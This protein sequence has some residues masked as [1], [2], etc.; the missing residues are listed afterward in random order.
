LL[1][2]WADRFAGLGM[3]GAI[4]AAGLVAP[5]PVG[6]ATQAQPHPWAVRAVE[7]EALGSVS[8]KA[9]AV[10]AI[11]QGKVTLSNRGF[12]YT[13]SFAADGAFRFPSVE[14]GTYALTTEIT[15]YNL[16]KT[17]SV[18]VAA[19]AAVS[20]P[21]LAIETYTAANNTYS[22]TWKQD[23]AYAGLPKTE[24][25]E[26]VVKPTVVTVLGKAYTMADVSYAQEL[27][28]RYGIVLVNDEAAW[29]QE[30]AYRLFAVLSRI[31]QT[32][33][34]D[35]KFDPSL[36]TR[37]WVLTT[38]FINQ[39]IDLGKLAQGEVRVST[40]AFTYAAPVVA[41]IDGV[42][43][44]YFSKRLHHALVRYVTNGGTDQAAVAKILWDRYGLL[45]DRD[46][47]PLQYSQFTSEPATR[48]QQWF[49]HPDEL[50]RVINAFEELPEGF[51]KIAGFKWL[52]RRL[53]GTVNPLYPEAPAIA[54]GNGYME[55][56]ESAFSNFDEAYMTRLI[57]HEKAHYIYQFIVEKALKKTWA[58]LGGWV[59]APNPTNPDYD[60]ITGWQTTKT[61][62][63]V[64]AYAHDKNP[65]EDFAESIAAYVNNPDRLKA[66]SMAKY[67]FIR[68]NV[69]HSNSYVAVIRPDLTFTVLNL[70][71][72]YE[73]PG[74]INRISTRVT[75]APEEDKTLEVE[76]EIT[77]LAFAGNRA[78]S[79]GARIL[80][81]VSPEYP[82]ATYFD[83]G[84]AR[85][86]EKGTIFRGTQKLSKH[87]R[88]GY[89]QMPN[90]TIR[91]SVGRERYESSLLYGWKCYIN[92]PLQD[93]QIPQVKRGSTTLSVR[94]DTLQGRPVQWVT[95]GW[96]T[97]ENTGLTSYFATLVPPGAYSLQ[98]WGR[99][100]V[101]NGRTQVEVLINEFM[102]TGRYTVNQIFLKDYG[103]NASY[104]YF[105]TSPFN[106]GNSD[107]LVDVL[108][109]PAPSIEITTPNPDSVGPE[110]DVN[111]ITVKA[112]PTNP[113]APDGETLVTI[114][115][116]VRDNAA[117]YGVGN[118]VL[119]DPQGGE[120]YRWIYHRNFYT[121]FFDGDPKAW[122]KYTFETILPRGS[123][124][125]IWG[126]LQMTLSDKGGNSK[127]YG[128]LETVRFDPNS[129]AAAD[130]NIVGDPVGQS[131]RTGET[132]R[133]S[134]QT[135]GS[136]TVSYEWFKDGVS[137]A[138]GSGAAGTSGARTAQLTVANAQA[139]DAGAYYCVVTNDAGRVVSKA[140]DVRYDPVGSRLGNVSLR[141][142]LAARQP[143]IVGLTM[144]GGAKPVLMRAVGPGLAPFGVTNAMLDP[145]LTLF[146]E[147][148][149][150]ATND[151]WTSENGL[152]STA[153]AIG[154]FPLTAGS[155]DA[156]L[157]SSIA[158]G[159]T[160]QVQGAVGGNVLVEAYDAGSGSFP[161]LTNVSARSVAGSGGDAMIAGFTILGTEPKRVLLRAVGPTL[162]AFGVTGVLADPKLDVYAGPN[163]IA[164]NDNWPASLASTFTAV[165][166]FALP[167][168]SRD[169]AVELT[170]APGGYTVHV[171]PATGAAGEVLI[172]IYEV[173]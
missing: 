101:V 155:K 107:G 67:E 77:P 125:G 72:S 2:R 53:D 114:T 113:T 4:A 29:T 100:T 68:D 74:K 152:V 168:G 75:G 158:N 145:T 87:V 58:E 99:Q 41:E 44:L 105:R 11:E 36:P 92:N 94:S 63:F 85:V 112:V 35:Y 3:V 161:R 22:Y 51:H 49:K 171:S 126:L 150:V 156:V 73:Y 146:E 88:S 52:V 1:A 30:Y 139:A 137:L 20:V 81:P 124:P 21:D 70:F 121:D 119:R 7:A 39:D 111:R 169:A 80:S 160:L 9:P 159:R 147:A 136:A 43:G 12:V 118:L 97:V 167:A 170:L 95:I 31:P 24:I 17:V 151:N 61:T 106:S 127:S 128:F 103:L 90:V 143:L 76:I 164:G 163:R 138:A 141:A 91:D 165:G 10:K 148:R 134:V 142:T 64:S 83:M 130:L 14:A 56:M 166:A 122:E 120:Y 65:N 117:G 140:A 154:A 96:D 86:D 48:F 27:L 25:A 135:A 133:L 132:I 46:G 19:G 55:Y 33:G 69:M 32:M 6:A 42:R 93:L 15:G 131:Y 37:R 71:P 54:W 79:I 47:A 5:A 162:S 59:Y 116:Y 157:L 173:P 60:D 102:P 66:R 104:T 18:E 98:S 50:I 57:L 23:Q 108:D 28:N 8:G 123:V 16:T 109:E 40:A 115:Y 129:T 82:V 153:A 26:S 38:D 34:T 62:E 45:I 144:S 110:L 172:E 84:F 149:V 78:E 89:W 13:A